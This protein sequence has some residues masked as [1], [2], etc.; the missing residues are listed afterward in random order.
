MIWLHCTKTSMHIVRAHTNY[1]NTD[2]KLARDQSLIFSL[3]GN[4]GNCIEE[5]TCNFASYNKHGYVY[6]VYSAKPDI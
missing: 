4:C 6:R 5:I 1:N 2:T 3:E